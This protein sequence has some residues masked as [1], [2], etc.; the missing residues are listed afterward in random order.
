VSDRFLTAVEEA[1]TLLQSTPG[2]G[3]IRSF[4]NPALREI[5]MWPLPRFRRYLVFYRELSD[6]IEIVRIVHGARDLPAIFEDE[7]RD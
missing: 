4:A 2:V 5:R 7:V 3:A 6:S 1:F